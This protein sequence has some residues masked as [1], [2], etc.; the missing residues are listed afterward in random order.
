MPTQY[1]QVGIMAA[2][3]PTGEFLPAVPIYREVEVDDSGFTKA[4]KDAA[5]WAAKIAARIIK[6]YK[7]GTRKVERGAST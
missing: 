1:K 6:T 5:D 2:R 3:S 4:E 7:D